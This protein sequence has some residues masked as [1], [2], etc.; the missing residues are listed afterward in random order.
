MLTKKQSDILQFITAYLTEHGY[1]PS[2][3]EIADHFRLSSR[4]TVH[5][6]IQALR[7]KGYVAFKEGVKRSLEPTKKFI[8][9]AKSV[10]L[11]LVGTITAGQPIHAIEE[12]ETI[13]IPAELVKDPMNTFVL[14]V[15]GESMIEEGIF[16]GDHVIV[17]RNPSPKNGDVVVALL[18]NEY[19]TLKKFFRETGRIRLQPA[20]SRLKPIYVKDVIIQGV[21][22][23]VIRKF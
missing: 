4:A 16:D 10:F 15:R 3:Q 1:P 5:E 13:A 12:Q 18:H 17:Q 20:N 9:F 2:Y 14:L 7:K 22:K 21:V 23:A 19:A 8:D 11:P 6:H